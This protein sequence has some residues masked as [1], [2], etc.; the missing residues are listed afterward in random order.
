MLF[1]VNPISGNGNKAEI[2]SKLTQKGF[3]VVFTEYPGHAEVLAREATQKKIVAVGGDGTVNE[4]ARGIL[5][6]DKILGI[7]PCGSGDGLA[8]HL[9]LSRNF[10][11]ALSTI[12]SDKY[13]SLDGATING[14]LFISV[15]G[16]G[17]DAMVSEHFAKS[18]KRGL[19]NYIEQ[20]LKLWRDFKPDSYTITIDGHQMV[21]EASLITV[22]NS[23]QWGNGAKITPHADSHDGVLD[24]TIAEMFHTI[25][26]PALGGLLL[27][28]H[29]DKSHRV[30]CLKGKHI[31]IHRNVPGPAHADGDWFEAGELI[32]IQVI[33]S[34]FRVLVP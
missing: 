9:G 10:K 13:T 32:E 22:G 2:V 18:G 15:C 33:P 20:G 30:H 3:N 17:F 8:L 31:T 7:I 27:T 16:V 23:N 4:V 24:V 29:I 1:I 11:K 14:R 5:G 28:G 19:F 26:I 25:D 12:L 21:Y 34:A 6:S